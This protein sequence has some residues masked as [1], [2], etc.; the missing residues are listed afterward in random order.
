MET[1]SDP[2]RKEALVKLSSGETVR[3][4]VP[5]AC[6]VFPGQEASLSQMHAQGMSGSFYVVKE[7][8]NDS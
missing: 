2:P 4:L 8:R 1:L 6:V 5:A 3:A 7:S